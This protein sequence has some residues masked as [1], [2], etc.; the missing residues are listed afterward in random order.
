M[1][2]WLLK[3]FSRKLLFVFGVW[4]A[5]TLIA[6]FKLL[7]CTFVEWSNFSQWLAGI[8]IGGNAV[9]KVSTQIGDKNV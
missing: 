8:Y 4:L 5:G 9:D 6:L 3:Q 2:A 7:P 1:K